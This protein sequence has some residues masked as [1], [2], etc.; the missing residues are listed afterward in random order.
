MESPHPVVLMSPTRMA[1]RRRRV[2]VVPVTSTTRDLPTEVP[3]DERDGLRRPCVAAAQDAVTIDQGVL[4]QLIATLSPEKL[5]EIDRALHV[6]LGMEL[7]CRV[8]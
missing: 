4:L 1:Q 8:G 7:P 5:S 2:T 6:A 3:L